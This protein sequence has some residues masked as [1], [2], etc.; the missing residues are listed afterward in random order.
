MPSVFSVAKSFA[1]VF[2]S[3]NSRNSRLKSFAVIFISGHSCP[4]VVLF[5]GCGYAAL[6]Q[7]ADKSEKSVAQLRSFRQNNLVAARPP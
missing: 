1:V 7:S 6:S 3:V 5:F 2:I 4:F